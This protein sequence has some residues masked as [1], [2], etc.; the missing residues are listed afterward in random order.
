MQ[1]NTEV[2]RAGVCES[3]RNT[4]A[5]ATTGCRVN[6]LLDE[7]LAGGATRRLQGPKVDS[8]S[9]GARR[10]YASVDF[11]L[12]FASAAEAAAAAVDLTNLPADRFARLV[13]LLTEK[14]LVAAKPTYPSHAVLHL[15]MR[16]SVVGLGG[17]DADSA[18]QGGNGA[19]GGG[20]NARDTDADGGGR[21]GDDAVTIVN[22][23]TEGGAGAGGAGGASAGAAQEEALPGGAVT[24]AAISTP[25]T[26]N[27]LVN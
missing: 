15:N 1:L 6:R 26:D 19:G 18:L 12:F 14:A 16:G 20:A 21:A 4:S 8:S 13:Q 3:L 10:Q 24:D 27:P 9:F 23:G 2:F 25:L 22:V 11:T 5:T 17:R 7:P